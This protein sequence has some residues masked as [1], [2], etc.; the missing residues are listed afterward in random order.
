MSRKPPTKQEALRMSQLKDMGCI[1]TR[2]SFG[3]FAGADIHHLT[4]GGRRLGHMQT[5]PLCPWFHRAVPNIGLTP[6]AMRELY[7]PSMAEGKRAFENAF[8][9]EEYL[10][11]ETNKWLGLKNNRD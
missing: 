1:V 2:L 9:T 6:D 3:A 4:K 8:G 7:G 5:I 11:E 10:L